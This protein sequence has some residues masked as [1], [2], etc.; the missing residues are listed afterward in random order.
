MLTSSLIGWARTQN[1]TC[2]AMVAVNVW[3]SF[4]FFFMTE[5]GPIQG[6]NT[7]DV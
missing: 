4:D 7:L 3:A 5:Q 2:N 6:D 1:D